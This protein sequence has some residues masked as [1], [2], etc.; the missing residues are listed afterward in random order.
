MAARSEIQLTAL[1][2]GLFDRYQYR[3]CAEAGE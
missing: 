2:G 1:C 3:G